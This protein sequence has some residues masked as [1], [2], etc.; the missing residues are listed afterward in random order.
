MF[1]FFSRPQH[2][3]VTPITTHRIRCSGPCTVPP[4]P[5]ASPYSRFPPPPRKR[6]VAG[7]GPHR[8]DGRSI[9]PP[10][11]LKARRSRQGKSAQ[12]KRTRSIPLS[13]PP[14]TPTTEDEDKVFLQQFAR[15]QFSQELAKAR[16][17]VKRSAQEAPAL[18]KARKERLAREEEEH[19]LERQRRIERQRMELELEKHRNLM[20]RVE[21]RRREA[22]HRLAKNAHII[23][24]ERLQAR[25]VALP[26][27][28]LAEQVANRLAR[29]DN[30]WDALKNENFDIGEPLHF[31][32][33]P[34][35]VLAHVTLPEQITYSAVEEF[36]FHP[37]RAV[38]SPKDRLRGEVL[39]WHPDKFDA[40]ILSKV[41]VEEIEMVREASGHVVRIL[42]QMMMKMEAQS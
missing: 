36:L 7:L 41:M 3:P 35:P 21:K 28:S 15:L 31:A 8:V 10:K 9:R 11:P 14:A 22:I 2:I 17:L 12:P 27:Q 19:R 16:L 33:M 6:Y 5:A 20:A 42:T 29:Y 34:W 23:A 37:L 1:N 39:R 38:K 30:Q 26:R 25:Q 32:Q 13:Q 18:N 4:E 24:K 40:K